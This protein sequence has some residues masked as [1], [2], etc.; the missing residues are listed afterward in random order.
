MS[1]PVVSVVIA[2][3]NAQEYVG[4]TIRSVLAQSLDSLELIVVNDGSTDGTGEVIRRFAGDRRV[5]VMD[6]QNAGCAAARN[7][8]AAQ[9]QGDFISIVD[10]DDVCWPKKL[11]RQVDCF[12]SEPRLAVV[13]THARMI[14]DEGRHLGVLRTP[15]D[16]LEIREGMKESMQF[17]H[18]TVMIRSEVYRQMGGYEESYPT[19]EDYEFL[20]RIVER[21]RASNVDEVLYDMRIHGGNKSFYFFEQQRLRNLLTRHLMEEGRTFDEQA[22]REFEG[23]LSREQLIAAGVSAQRIDRQMVS[24]YVHRVQMLDLL[25]KRED[26][27]DFLERAKAYVS[28]HGLG[29]SSRAELCALRSLR[30]MRQRRWGRCVAEL[31]GGLLLDSSVVGQRYKES[32]RFALHRW[33]TL[34]ALD[35][36]NGPNHSTS[37]RRSHST[38]RVAS[39]PF[40]LRDRPIFCGQRGR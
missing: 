2:A 21:H 20:R 22:R 18:A 17:C 11:E 38:G 30:A 3:Y 6:Q 10:A 40:P 24:N 9:A 36:T 34:R 39:L 32:A 16:P 37:G 5:R 25:G 23:Q 28:R 7:R 26:A 31:L 19:S 1:R 27:D 14:D 29:S 4:Q 12:V 35:L 8:G 13:G 33:Y 15:T